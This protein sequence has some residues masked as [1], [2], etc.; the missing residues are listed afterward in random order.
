MEENKLENKILEILE[1][2]KR[3]FFD[4]NMESVSR[5]FRDF[6]GFSDP[7]IL[8]EQLNKLLENGKISV[9]FSF[10]FGGRDGH[11]ITTIIYPKGEK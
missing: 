8:A 3:I 7:E 2:E 4:M 11:F 10:G 9:K 6:T 1:K 5:V